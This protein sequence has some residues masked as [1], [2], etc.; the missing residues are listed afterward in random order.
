MWPNTCPWA[1][2]QCISGLFFSVTQAAT[3]REGARKCARAEKLIFSLSNQICTSHNT[4]GSD[5]FI[6][7]WSRTNSRCSHLH[8]IR[9]TSCRTGK[10]II[11]YCNKSDAWP[12]LKVTDVFVKAV[13]CI[14]SIEVIYTIWLQI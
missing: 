1:T 2:A 9:V 4:S 3:L 12:S 5:F 8:K 6:T 7:L 10:L 13:Y 11:M 14:C